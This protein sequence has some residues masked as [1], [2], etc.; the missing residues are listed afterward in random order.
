VYISS[1]FFRFQ[2]KGKQKC[3]LKV[4][5]MLN[6]IPCN[7]DAWEM[8]GLFFNSEDA[9]SMF[10]E[11]SIDFSRTTWWQHPRIST[12]LCR[13]PRRSDKWERQTERNSLWWKDFNG[14][15]IEKNWHRNIFAFHKR[16][17]TSWPDEWL[18][19][20]Q[21][22]ICSLERVIWEQW[23]SY[24]DPRKS[25]TLTSVWSLFFKENYFASRSVLSLEE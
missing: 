16:S 21:E 5:I 25:C 22:C 18:S 19:S 24:I 2:R 7:E 1:E 14:E 3:R 8:L 15:S 4:V 11:T 12:W 6:Q 17:G 23:S 20:Y 13:L 10:S 9:S